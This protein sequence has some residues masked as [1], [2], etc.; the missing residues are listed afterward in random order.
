M[1]LVLTQTEKIGI[2]SIL[3]ANSKLQQFRVNIF[4]PESILYKIF[5]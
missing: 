1:Q 2:D 5:T 4:L 3:Y